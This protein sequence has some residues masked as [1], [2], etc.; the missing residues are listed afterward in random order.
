M[1]RDLSFCP[2]AHIFYFVCVLQFGSVD[3]AAGAGGKIGTLVSLLI[4]L[5]DPY[6]YKDSILLNYAACRPAWN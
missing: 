5:L 6:V 1:S 3:V 2:H 4:P